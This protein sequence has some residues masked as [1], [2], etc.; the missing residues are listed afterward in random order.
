MSEKIKSEMI[1][2]RGAFV[3][4]GSAAARAAGQILHLSRSRRMGRISS[5]PP[6]PIKAAKRR[7]CAR[8]GW[9]S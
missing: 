6:A 9:R 1:S 4:L 3:L 7:G 5:S 2:R 8:S